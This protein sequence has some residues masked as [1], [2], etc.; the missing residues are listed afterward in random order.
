M[1]ELQ[2]EK[3]NPRQKHWEQSGNLFLLGNAF[4]GNSLLDAATLESQTMVLETEVDVVSFLKCLSGSFVM[5]FKKGDICWAAVDRIRSIPLYYSTDGLRISDSPMPSLADDIDWTLMDSLKKLEF[6]QGTSTSLHDWKQIQAGEFLWIENGRPMP[7]PYTSHSRLKD[8]LL[9]YD[10]LKDKF[11][12]V[13]DGMANRFVQYLDGRPV[14][15]PLSGGFDSRFV[16]SLLKSTGYSNISAFTYGQPDG[17]EAKV[18]QKVCEAIEV[19]WHFI[20]YDERV[21]DG[22]FNDQWDAFIEY[23]SGWVSVPQEQEYFALNQLKE[24]LPADT[25]IC[26]GFSGD[27][28][29]GSFLPNEF[30][31]KKW[32]KSPKSSQEY[33]AEQLTRSP[34]VDDIQVR[35]QE[36]EEYDFDSFYSEVEEWILRERISKYVV[37]GVRCYEF[38]GFDWYLPLWDTEFVTFWNTVPNNF[39]IDK[40]LYADVL[41]DLFFSPMDI[42]FKPGG[43]DQIFKKGN[44]ATWVKEYAPTSVRRFAKKVLFPTNELEINNLNSFSVLLQ[45]RMGQE[46]PDFDKPVN[47]A[48]AEYLIYRLQAKWERQ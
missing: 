19:P 30:F 24:R 33:I 1:V 47:E 18:A 25:V 15:V 6:V 44:W 40:R 41:T 28:Q 31:K 32:R 35:S 46:R 26:P 43:F 2:F 7:K 20:E 17:H 36:G 13:V 39:R 4:F 16:L 45:Q 10:G 12:D 9:G 5:V 22:V 8:S 42:D 29:A 11:I 38:F 3:T 14:A 21:F 23:A 34:M 48:M 27:V 37:N